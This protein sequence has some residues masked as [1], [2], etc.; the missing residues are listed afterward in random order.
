MKRAY[1]ADVS[2]KIKT[3]IF[4]RQLSAGVEV[5]EMVSNSSPRTFFANWKEPIEK[6]RDHVKS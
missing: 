1:P 3:P 5:G 6:F 4:T 2:L